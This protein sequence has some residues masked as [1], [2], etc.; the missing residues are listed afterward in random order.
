VVTMDTVRVIP[1]SIHG[2]FTTRK[3]KE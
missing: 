1:T 2:G 3:L